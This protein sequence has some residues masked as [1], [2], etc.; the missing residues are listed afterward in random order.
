[1]IPAGSLLARWQSAATADEKQRLA[2]DLETLL[3]SGPPAKKDSPD[4][5]LYRQLSSL[6]GP[7]VSAVRHPVPATGT[8][9]KS[10]ATIEKAVGLDAALF[11]KHPSA[12]KIDPANL[13]VQAPNV[14]EIRLPSD[15]VE[16]CEFVTGGTLDVTTGGEGSVQM[17]LLTSRSEPLREVSPD[18]PVIVRDGSAARRRFETAFD[19]IRNVFPP[20]LCYTKIVPVDEVITLTLFYREDDQLQR[21]MLNTAEAAELDRLW[22]ELHFVSGDALMRVDAFQQIL[23]YAS[24]DGDPRVLEPLRKPIN[25]RAIEFRRELLAAEPRHLDAVVALADRAFRRPL[26][27]TRPSSSVRSTRGCAKRTSLTTRP[28]DWCWHGYSWSPAFLIGWKVRCPGRSQ[29]RFGL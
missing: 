24:Q 9:S 8:S 7:L 13:C 11:G 2:Q 21:L 28:Y 14:V 16:G 10:A 17:Q 3:K 25:D 5:L 23:E 4:G 27:R 1:M 6:R 12:P 18:L 26:S 29:R 19:V 22:T 15:L 20:A